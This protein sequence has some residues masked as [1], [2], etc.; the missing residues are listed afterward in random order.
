M[1]KRC[2]FSKHSQGRVSTITRNKNGEKNLDGAWTNQDKEDH[3]EWA[4]FFT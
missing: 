3:A 4:D 2:L 1:Q